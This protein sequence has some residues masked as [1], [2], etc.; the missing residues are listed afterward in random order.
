MKKLI[1]ILLSMVVRIGFADVSLVASAD[2]S[3]QWATT[4]KD[5]HV[6]LEQK[7][8]VAEVKKLSKS[9][10]VANL[11]VVAVSSSNGF[12]EPLV[13]VSGQ[14]IDFHTAELVIKTGSAV[15]AV[16][17]VRGESSKG[18]A[19]A[20]GKVEERKK[21]LVLLKAGDTAELKIYKNKKLVDSA[22]LS[23]KGSSKSISALEK[24]CSTVQ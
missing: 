7:A 11:E 20:L 5:K 18:L 2:T 6:V 8:C 9:G 12:L 15:E 17:L 22:V 21:L 23:L 3:L 1:F 14:G 19:M 16:Q 24:S 10:K 4:I 13:S